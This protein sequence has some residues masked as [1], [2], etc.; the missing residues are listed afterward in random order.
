MGPAAQV[1][2]TGA[3]ATMGGESPPMRP[4]VPGSIIGRRDSQDETGS[5]VERPIAPPRARH[6]QRTPQ[7][8]EA[9]ALFRREGGSTD[10]ELG[11]ILE[12]EASEEDREHLVPYSS[13][14]TKR[15]A[16]DSCSGTEQPQQGSVQHAEAPP[17]PMKVA[18]LVCGHAVSASLLLVVNKWA[19]KV[20]PYIWVLTTLQF[21]PT[22][23]L[24]SL[25]NQAGVME[26]DALERNK[27]VAF[28]PAAGMFFITLTAGNAIVKHTNVDTFIV[29]RSLV[30]IPCAFLETFVLGEPRPRPLSWLGLITILLGAVLY[31]T[32]NRGIAVS[33]LA[34]M[35]LFIVMMPVDGVLIKHLINTSGLNTTWGLVLYQNTLAGAFGIV[36]TLLVELSPPNAWHDA[37]A[38]LS[39]GGLQTWLPVLL[40]MLLGVS[41]SFFQMSVRKVVSSTAFMVLGVSNKLLALLVNQLTMEANSSFVSIAGVVTSIFGAVGFQQTVKGKGI[42]QAQRAVVVSQKNR[43]ERAMIAMMIGL[44][45]AGVLSISDAGVLINHHT[46]LHG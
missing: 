46:W 41:V 42:A 13:E 10:I 32:A 40:S 20:F 22:A 33:G 6:Q 24:V 30:P 23:L 45:W 35:I 9:K 31:A 44:V 38:R 7:G 36:C 1:V 39:T 17:S 5:V 27:L 11:E 37:G 2:V 26:V 18:L 21:V 28:L 3:S 29:M 8:S 43:N 15:G 12:G 16:N 4:L 25:L 14:D 19:L 34:W